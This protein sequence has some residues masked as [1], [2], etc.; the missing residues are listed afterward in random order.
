MSWIKDKSGAIYRIEA[1]TAV[2]PMEL[3]SDKR[4]QSKV[5]DVHACIT[6]VGGHTHS[7]SLDFA[8][9]VKL[10]DQSSEPAASAPNPA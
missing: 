1:I 5:T 6:T 9:V 3:R 2:V 7:T 8:D 4:D 10:V